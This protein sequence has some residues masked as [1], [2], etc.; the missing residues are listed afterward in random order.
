[1]KI[2]PQGKHRRKSRKGASRR[3]EILSAA[4]RRFAEDGYQSAAIGDIARD[5]GLSLPGLLHHYPTKVDLL[6]AVL[7]KRDHNG[8]LIVGHLPADVGSLLS[9]LVEV[10]RKNVEIAEVV[11]A[12]AVLNGESLT[13]DHPAK[14][15]FV[16]RS[17]QLQSE[18]GAIFTQAASE[19]RVRADF[20][21]AALATELIAVMDGLQTL[22]LR[23]PERFDMVAAL[24]LYIDRLSRDI[25][26]GLEIE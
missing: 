24:Q 21:G 4:M 12:F 3:E 13:K 7:D 22:W 17:R 16:T 11:R 1:M 14:G 6:L 5:V 25:C 26:L 2:E 20:N 8:A 19:G 9:G 10:C 15:W 18:I 23:D